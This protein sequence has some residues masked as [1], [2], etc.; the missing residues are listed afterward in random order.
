MTWLI[1]VALRPLGA[2]ALF[3]LAFLTAGLLWPL[4][5]DGRVKRILYDR[6]LRHRRKWMFAA[7]VVV[8]FYGTVLAMVYAYS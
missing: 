4:I 6:T 1:A 8:S 3:G 7:L 5:P 2:L